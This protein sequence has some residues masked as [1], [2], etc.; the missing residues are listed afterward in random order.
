MT[1]I[2]FDC[3]DDIRF[4]IRCSQI[5]HQHHQHLQLLL[6]PPA[7]PPQIHMHFQ[8]HMHI[9]IHDHDHTAAHRMTRQ[10]TSEVSSSAAPRGC[11]FS[12][13]VTDPWT[14]ATAPCSIYRPP[15]HP[16]RRTQSL[17]QPLRS[18][19]SCT[20]DAASRAAALCSQSLS[21]DVE[22]LAVHEYNPCYLASPPKENRNN[23]HRTLYQ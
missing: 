12:V 14:Q 5:V 13:A 1:T 15:L 21:A 17:E 2:V 19:L 22:H 7:P 8:I 23:R 10:H 20:R 9:H 18:P 4:S 6:P 16:D 11:C 3:V